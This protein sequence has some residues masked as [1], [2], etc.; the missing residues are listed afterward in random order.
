MTVTV[1]PYDAADAEAWDVLVARSANGTLLHTRRYLGYHGDRFAD[2]SLLVYDDGRL[3]GVLPAAL[4]PDDASRVVSHPGVTYGGLVHLPSLRGMAVVAAVEAAREA[5]GAERLL[6]KAVPHVYARAGAQDDLWAL[7]VL[8]ARRVRCDLS[9]YA[10]LLAPPALSSMRTRGAAK[11]RKAGVVAANDPGALD[12][13]WR[14]LTANL[15]ERHGVRPVH[16]ADEMRDLLA[17]C[18]GEIELHVATRDGDVLAG[19]VVYVTERVWHAQYI[20]STPE[21][22]DA[23]SLD[24]VFAYGFDR[25]RDA[26]ARAYSFGI[27]NED[28]GRTLNEGLY[29]YKASFGGGSVVHEQYEL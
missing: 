3:A 25:A 26:G 16:T 2:R 27:S 8:G 17:R 6:Y 5:W 4:D 19:V 12:A 23:G 11:A 15:A 10:D 9:W 28:G 13:Y 21:G 24:A 1:R 14:V 7:F 18:P 20:A 29:R 22:R